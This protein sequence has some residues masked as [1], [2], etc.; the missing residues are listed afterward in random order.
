MS[1][2]LD[3]PWIPLGPDA[4]A[5]VWGQLGVYEIA[6]ESGQVVF[7]GYAGGHSRFGLRGELESRCRTEPQGRAFRYEVNMSYLT[8][9]RE[10]LMAFEADHGRL[11]AQ[12]ERPSRLG[13]LHPD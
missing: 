8:R 2:R 11:P 12:N 10:L 5:R 13:R 7:I 4:V 9:Y 3:K 1:I 6:D